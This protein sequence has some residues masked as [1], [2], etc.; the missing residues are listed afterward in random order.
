MAEPRAGVLGG[1]VPQHLPLVG[2]G[3][4]LPGGELGAQHDEVV[5][6]PVE[7]LAGGRGQPGVGDAGPGAVLGCVMDLQALGQGVATLGGE[8][9]LVVLR[10][11]LARTA[12]RE[13]ILVGITTV[14]QI[15]DRLEVELTGGRD[16]Q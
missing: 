15:A 1:E 11:Q 7:A 12:D 10:T 13:E 3:G 9:K 4:P 2:V 16:A 8:E 6:A 14:G 5:N